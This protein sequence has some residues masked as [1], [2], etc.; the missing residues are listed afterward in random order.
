VGLFNFIKSIFLR[1]PRPVRKKEAKKVKLI[2]NPLAGEGKVKKAVRQIRKSLHRYAPHLK[3]DIFFSRKMGDLSVTAKESV[4]EGYEIVIAAGG[5]GAINE[6]VQGLANTPIVLG[7]IPLGTANVFAEEIEIPKDI[8]QACKILASGEV[9]RVDLGKA[10][11]H[12]FLWMASMG[13]DAQLAKD[14]T[15]EVRERL[16]VFAYFWFAVN[17]LNKIKFSQIKFN[18]E[19]REIKERAFITVIGNAASYDGDLKIRSLESIDDGYLDVCLYTKPTV[20]GVIRGILR[21]LGK[22]YTYYKDVKYWGVKHYRVKKVLIESEPPIWVQTDGE[23]IGET[24]VEFTIVPQALSV[25]LPRRP[26]EKVNAEC[27]LRIAECGM[28]I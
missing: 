24:P 4:D 6:V 17:R 25:I 27:G 18:L 28:K 7:I 21:F 20:L 9:R 13:T 26:K 3:V 11:E 15:S 23:V 1:L 22:R 12:Y 5:D 16:G 19:G 8:D 2:I 10:G 14:L